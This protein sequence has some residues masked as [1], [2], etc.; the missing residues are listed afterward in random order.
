MQYKQIQKSPHYGRIYGYNEAGQKIETLDWIE[1]K[2]EHKGQTYTIAELLEKQVDNEKTMEALKA[3]Y[4]LLAQKNRDLSG[5]ITTLKLKTDTLLIALQKLTSE[6]A[7]IK[8]SN[9]G[10]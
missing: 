2:V 5:Q 10:V 1:L 6:V 7:K 8:S 9:T 3:S 4:G